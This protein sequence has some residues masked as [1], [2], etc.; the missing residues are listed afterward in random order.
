MS[1]QH[2]PRLAQSGMG[3][4]NESCAIG[5]S[6]IP[7]SLWKQVREIACRFPAFQECHLIFNRQSKDRTLAQLAGQ[8][9]L[10]DRTSQASLFRVSMSPQ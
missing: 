7:N 1:E 6:D 2:F 3:V 9:P 5:Y 10:L 8:L 4:A